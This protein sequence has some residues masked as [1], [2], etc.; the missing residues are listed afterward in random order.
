[1]RSAVFGGRRVMATP[2]PFPVRFL[3]V[4]GELV[5]STAGTWITKPPPRCPNGHALGPGEVLVG[6]QGAWRRAQPGHAGPARRS[7][8]DIWKPEVRLSTAELT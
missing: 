1:M 7:L 4:L 3:V 2:H 6:H 5:Q 8:S